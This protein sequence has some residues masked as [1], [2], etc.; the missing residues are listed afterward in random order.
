MHFLLQECPVPFRP[1]YL[2]GRAAV[3]RELFAIVDEI[4]Y[5]WAL[6]WRW[7]AVCSKQGTSR[8]EKW[9]ASRATRLNGTPIRV[10]LHKEILMR[11]KGLPPTRLHIIGDHMNGDSLNCRRRNL[12]WATPRENRQNYNGIF[13]RQLAIDF[14]HKPRYITKT[15]ERR[16]GKTNG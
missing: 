4:D 6:Q 2:T 11:A 16:D 8:K 9:Y 10:F 7:Q 12:R 15:Q 13:A 5:D 14:G 3:D 1:I